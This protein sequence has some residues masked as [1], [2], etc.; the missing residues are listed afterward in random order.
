MDLR[1][2]WENGKGRKKTERKRRGKLKA[3]YKNKEKIWNMVVETNN[4]GYMDANERKEC[5]INDDFILNICI[6]VC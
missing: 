5:K 2:I 3:L 6:Y 1:P 4:K